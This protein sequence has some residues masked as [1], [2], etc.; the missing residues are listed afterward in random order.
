MKKRDDKKQLSL[1]LSQSVSRP[2]RAATVP[3]AP[4]VDLATLQV[5]R[6]AVR[7]VASSGI[8]KI[9]PALKKK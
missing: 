4:F 9:N 2:E 8:F 7:R 3:V 1:D 6:D 5:R